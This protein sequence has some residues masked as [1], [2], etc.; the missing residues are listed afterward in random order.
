MIAGRYFV[1]PHA[2]KQF[3]ARIAPRLSYDQALGAIIR[4]L[5]ETESEPKPCHSGKAVYIR[6]RRP[7]AFRAVIAPGEGE[8]P[9]VI[10]ILR[11][12]KG[13][14]RSSQQRAR[15]RRRRERGPSYG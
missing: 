2:V 1:T 10:T 8:L 12:G 5:E 15:E 14:G 9:A 11:S 6:V 4:G 7:Y 13:R 3:R